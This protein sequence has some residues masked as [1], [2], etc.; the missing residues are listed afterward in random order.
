MKIKTMPLIRRM[1]FRLALVIAAMIGTDL[2]VLSTHDIVNFRRS[3]LDAVIAVSL[4][5]AITTGLI[6][7]II[8]N[9]V[10]GLREQFMEQAR[11]VMK[12]AW[13]CRD[14]FAGID[15]AEFQKFF[16][17][18]VCPLA[19]KSLRQWS[20]IE[21]IQNWEKGIEDNLPKLMKMDN[22]PP[23]LYTLIYRYLLPL[24]DEISQLGLLSIRRAAA[25]L[26]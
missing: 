13:D 22:P 23:G 20:Q 10:K 9:Y 11:R 17:Q 18:Y 7:A 21:N 16:S 15:S 26:T 5:F 14:Y 2:L 8:N 25:T 4:I 24:E 12:L 1:S 19:E 3:F 6:M